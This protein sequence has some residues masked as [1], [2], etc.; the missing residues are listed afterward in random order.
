VTTATTGTTTVT[1]TDSIG[2]TKTFAYT[3]TTKAVLGLSLTPTVNGVD[4]GT[5]YTAFNT[6]T[7]AGIGGTA[8]LE[9]VGGQIAATGLTFNT[10]T[11]AV[12]G[13]PDA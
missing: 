2:R 1:L 9:D 5:T 7:S 10:S 6:P 3:Y 13:T 11:G 4:I 8:L 12:T